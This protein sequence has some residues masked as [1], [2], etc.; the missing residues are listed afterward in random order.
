MLGDRQLLAH[1]ALDG[2]L[3]A[4]TVSEGRVRLHRLG[5]LER[6]REQLDSIT[7]ALH[8][9]NRLQGSDDARIAA[10]E[11]MFAAAAELAEH[12][13]PP[14]IA[15][16]DAPVVIVPTGVLHDVPWGLL[17]PLA[18]REVSVNPS[19]AA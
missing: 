19:L 11:L 1:A 14:D 2:E 17:T 3:L 15:Q 5:T 16:S 7:F 8:R 4:V 13:L 6:P 12:A 9:L 10:A 18:G